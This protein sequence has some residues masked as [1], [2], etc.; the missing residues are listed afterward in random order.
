VRNNQDVIEVVPIVRKILV[1]EGMPQQMRVQL[2]SSDRTVL[3]AQIP[4]PTLA[5][6][7]TFANENLAALHWGPGFE[8]RLNRTAG[9]LARSSSGISGMIL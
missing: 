5:Q 2:D 7:P 6:R 3:V 4:E 1:S 9:V 8:V